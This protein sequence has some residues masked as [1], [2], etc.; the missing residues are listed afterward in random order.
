MQVSRVGWQQTW[1]RVRGA[2]Q[3]FQANA[4]QPGLR[5]TRCTQRFEQVTAALQKLPVETFYSE[6]EL[7]GM[8]G[9]EL[10]VTGKDVNSQALPHWFRGLGRGS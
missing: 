2:F 5:G 10:K 8:P 7:Q 6:A 3:G 4:G 9:A 1:H